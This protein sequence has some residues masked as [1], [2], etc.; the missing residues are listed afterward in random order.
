M[1]LYCGDNL[2]QGLREVTHLKSL[3]KLIILDLTGNALAALPEYRLFSVYH[4]SRL[5]ASAFPSAFCNASCATLLQFV[6]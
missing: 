6:T 1:E 4:L 2:V 5:K 3:T